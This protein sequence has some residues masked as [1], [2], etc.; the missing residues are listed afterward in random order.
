MQL[1]EKKTLDGVLGLQRFLRA[2]STTRNGVA[3]STHL[4]V[5]SYRYQR[6]IRSVVPLY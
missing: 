2:I 3:G 5:T 1:P 6:M 4:A